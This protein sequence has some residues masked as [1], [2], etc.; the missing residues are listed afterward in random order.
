MN[1]LVAVPTGLVAS[2]FRA[3]FPEQ[4]CCETVHATFHFPVQNDL[5][6]SINW[7]LSLY[8]I[9]IID[10]VSMI[11]NIIFHH[12]PK[13]INV[14]LFRPVLM[15]AGDAGQQQPFSRQTG[16]IMQLTSTLNNSSFIRNTYNY[17]LN[18]V[19][20]ELSTLSIV[21]SKKPK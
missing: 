13:T 2:V 12:I 6:P 8:D 17:H 20:I 11:P 18:T 16:K 3:V 4:V 10:E 19:N 21:V 7:Q 14:L 15:V 1:V 9:I 5:A